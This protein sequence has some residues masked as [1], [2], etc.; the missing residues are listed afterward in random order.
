M[1][2]T[3]D[4]EPDLLAATREIAQRERT[5]AGRVVSRLLRQ[6]LT[7]QSSSNEAGAALSSTGFR[8]FSSRGV[9]V[10][11]AEIDRLRDAEGT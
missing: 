6:A 3:L 5:S 9:A 2:T 8:A 10:T 11:N 7:Q 4:I 1:R